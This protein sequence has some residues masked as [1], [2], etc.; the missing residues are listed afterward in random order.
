MSRAGRGVALAIVVHG[1]A[2]AAA[3]SAELSIREVDPPKPAATGAWRPDQLPG[4]HVARG[5]RNIVAAWLAGPT[6][7]YG[8]GVLGD[9]IEASRLVVELRSGR[10]LGHELPASRVFEDLLPRLVD[11]D[12][13][14]DD[15]VLIV[16]TD[17]ALGA[18]LTVYAVVNDHLVRK[19]MTPF[20]GQAFRWLNPLGVGD[21]DG[22]GRADIALVATPHI[23]GRLRLY[24]YTAPILTRFAETGGVSTHAMG[25][26][27]LGLGRVVRN[28]DRDRL[29]LPNQSRESLLLLEWTPQGI[30]ELAR[31][32]L[33]GAILT[34]LQPAG[35]HRW[36]FR[37]KDGLHLEVRVH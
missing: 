9:R 4:S 34:S 2:T 22:D 36:H 6:P 30:R 10:T 18:S 12:A 21:F 14:G 19:S 7:R 28:A 3:L 29:L 26:R 27:E 11:L 8:H 24:R 23:G 31:L 20:L 33:P 25:S 35:D 5:E 37:T 1:V 32:A 16:E 17:S 15:E 13:D